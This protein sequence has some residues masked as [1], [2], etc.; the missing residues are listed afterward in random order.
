MALF[1]TTRRIIGYNFSGLQAGQW[2]SLDD[3]TR[4]QYL[5]TTRAGAHVVRWQAADG[6]KFAKRDAQANKPLRAFAKHYGAR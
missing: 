4:G 2:V 1:K 5:G 3:G 6:P